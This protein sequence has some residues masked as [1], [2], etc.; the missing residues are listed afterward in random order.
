MTSLSG[1]FKQGRRV[2]AADSSVMPAFCEGRYF[3]HERVT[4]ET[5]IPVK[6]RNLGA[7]KLLE[8]ERWGAVFRGGPLL[9]ARLCPTD[10]HRFHFPDDGKVIETLFSPR[11]IPFRQPPGIAQARGYLL[12]Q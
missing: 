11:A 6:G 1:K 4:E 10:Y 12:H 3:G 7:E 5:L 9:L 8:N 2:F